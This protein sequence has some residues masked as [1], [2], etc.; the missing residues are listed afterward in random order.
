MVLSCPE[1]DLGTPAYVSMGKYDICQRLILILHILIL[2]YYD[3]VTF[4]YLDIMILKHCDIE[5][6]LYCD[7]EITHTKNKWR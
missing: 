5:I 6:L 4:L 2:R 7:I 3:N 1:H